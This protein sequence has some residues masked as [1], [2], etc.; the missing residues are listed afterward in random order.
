MTFRHHF[1]V[2][3][4]GVILLLAIGAF[5]IGFNRE[6]AAIERFTNQFHYKFD[7]LRSSSLLGGE[8][9][10]NL[11]VPFHRQEH[12]LSC[13]IA[14]LKMVLNFFGI[15]VS[16]SELIAQLPFDMAKKVPS[17]NIWGD[18]DFGFVGDIDGEMGKTG[19]GVY[20]KPVSI[21]ASRYINAR[22][23][24]NTSLSEVLEEVA[25]GRP[26]IVWGH[27]ASGKDISWKTQEGKIVK[28]VYGEHARVLKGFRGTVLNPTEIFLLDPV[29]GEIRFST[30][31]FLKDWASLDNRA[32]IVYY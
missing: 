4:G 20:E 19:Y 25:K 11:D 14:S 29:Y 21:V 17:K 16:E 2:A 27:I 5:A 3:L 24:R 6:I 12:S 30:K 10:V 26:V 32:V 13:E 28:A 18:P 15:Q 31:E 7:S 8:I 22:P 9:T 23:V 1:F